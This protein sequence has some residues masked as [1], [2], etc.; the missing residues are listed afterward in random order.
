METIP[1]RG[2]PPA[3]E[4]PLARHLGAPTS[5]DKETALRPEA[6]RVPASKSILTA[7]SGFTLLPGGKSEIGDLKAAVRLGGWGLLVNFG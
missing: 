6:K 5:S 2:G 1:R 3:T 7:L 4:E